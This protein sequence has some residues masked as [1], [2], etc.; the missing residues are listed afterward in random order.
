M[1]LNKH[2]WEEKKE[3]HPNFE[4]PT[5][6]DQVGGRTADKAGGAKFRAHD[7]THLWKAE[8]T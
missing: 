7:E 8:A 2:N 5:W 4:S 6:D 1:K 3:I